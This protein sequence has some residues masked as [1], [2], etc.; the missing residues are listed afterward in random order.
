MGDIS[1]FCE[2]QRTMNTGGYFGARGRS[3][4]GTAAK[5]RDFKS[6]V[7]TCSTTRAKVFEDTVVPEL[8]GLEAGVGIEPASTALQAAA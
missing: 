1:R 7:S 4:T 2:L 5:P 3:R 8:E 6:L